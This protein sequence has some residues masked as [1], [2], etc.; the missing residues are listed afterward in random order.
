MEPRQLTKW[1]GRRWFLRG[2]GIVAVGTGPVA[3]SVLDG[4]APLAVQERF[5][6]IAAA[7]GARRVGGPPIGVWESLPMLAVDRSRSSG[8]GQSGRD[9]DPTGEDAGGLTGPI[10]L[11]RRKTLRDAP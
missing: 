3:V 11:A 7:L 1:R 8:I 10:V 2:L 6:R 4:A 5:T 9:S